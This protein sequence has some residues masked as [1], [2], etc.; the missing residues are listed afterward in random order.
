MC[1]SWN[2]KITTPPALYILSLFGLCGHER[3]TN[4]LLIPFF[5]VGA[6]RFRKQFLIEKRLY[7]TALIVLLFPVL[8]HSSLLY[9]TDLLS[10][11]VLLWGFSCSSPGWA[12]I[13]FLF[14]V[15][16]RQTNIIW[17]GLYGGV[18]LIHIIDPNNFFQSFIHGLMRL[19]ALILLALG[20]VVFFILNNFRIVLGDHHAHE[21][22]LHIM[23]LCYFFSFT[24]IL[25]APYFFFTGHLK[26]ALREFFV[27]PLRSLCFCAVMACCAYFFT[28]EHPYLLA[29]N[30]H[31][32]FY[33]W[34]KWFRRHW[35]CRYVVA[36]FY[37]YCFYL[38]RCS[39]KHI[40]SHITLLSLL[41]IAA[42]LVPLPLF[43]T[44]YFIVPFVLWRL[45]LT[46]NTKVSLVVELLYAVGI[47]LIVLYLFFLKPFVWKHEPGALQ[48]FMW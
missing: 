46:D 20:F 36:P 37:L 25:A 47:N 30:R 45:C 11:T 7:S 39:V 17:A 27:H 13:F 19:R 29:D 5:Y 16:T 1:F 4:S 15:L 24:C 2:E 28:I 12:S 22:K 44:R 8:F 41:A 21:P 40:A 18:N 14:A 9:Y 26:K 10:V 33:I 32:T 34:R 48:R 23:Q 3:Y 43:E 31:F 6:I 35:I 38:I 42:V